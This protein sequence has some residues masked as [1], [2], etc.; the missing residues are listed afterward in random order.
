MHINKAN[1]NTS[2]TKFILSQQ[3]NQH[4]I[5]NTTNMK[6]L[7]PSLLAFSTFVV[8]AAGDSN[9]TGSS[10][11]VAT[12]TVI[13]DNNG[14][15]SS[16]S[17]SSFSANSENQYAPK[18][19]NVSLLVFFFIFIA[20]F[21]FF[22]FSS[23]TMGHCIHESTLLSIIRYPSLASPHLNDTFGSFNVF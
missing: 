4:K 11:S 19:L 20:L 18:E 10:S 21:C 16:S 13:V 6:L 7:S 14:P 23:S 1:N 8:L 3:I 2:N 12:S 15:R 9:D 22:I 17:R 5:Q